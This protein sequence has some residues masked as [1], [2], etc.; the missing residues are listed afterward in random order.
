MKRPANTIFQPFIL[1][2]VVGSFVALCVR[3]NSNAVATPVHSTIT[4]PVSPDQTP[5]DVKAQIPLTEA[6][7]VAVMHRPQVPILC[8]HQIREW[9]PSDSKTAKD[10]IVPVE[11]F[12]GQIKALAENGYHTILPD[13]LYDYLVNGTALP[14]KPILLTYD[15]TRAEQ[16]TIAREEMNKYGFKGVFFIMTVSLGKP[17]YMTREEVKQLSDEGNVIGS[18]TWN[19]SNVKNY[20]AK[21]WPL[22]VDKPSQQLEN[23][24]G[25]P[26]EYFAYPFGLWNKPA[27]EQLK[28]RHFK[29]AFQLSEKR[30]ENEPLFTIRRIIVPGEWST[31]TMEKWMANSF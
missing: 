28:E 26:I 3:C 4:H 30:D 21:D 10:Y 22:Q 6:D 25:K 11:K 9:S 18:H 19:H 29:A 2:L 24:I 15:D 27:I 14:S 8:Y 7:P 13:Q 1:F 31:S 16:F 5:P 20:T 12:K 23:V 17:G